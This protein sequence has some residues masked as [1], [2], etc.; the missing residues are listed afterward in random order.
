MNPMSPLPPADMQRLQDAVEHFRAGRAEAALPLA[1]ALAGRHPGVGVVS[2]LLGSV[3]HALGEHAEAAAVLGRAAAELPGDAQAHSNLGNALAVLG[4]IDE[5]IDAHR[6]A[7]R[8]QPEQATL[9]YN[10]GCV[11]LQAG[12]R[13]EAAD[14]WAEAQTRAPDDA[15]LAAL[16]REL[17]LELGDNG[18]LMDFCRA[19]IARGRE[20]GGVL[21]LAGALALADPAGDIDEAER[22]LVAALRLTRD[23]A[24]SWSNLCVLRCRQGRFADAVDAGRQAVA[25]APEWAQGH[26]NLALALREAGAREEARTH[27]LEALQLDGECVDAYYNLGCIAADLGE[28]ELAR[29]AGIEAVKRMPRPGWLLQAAHACRHV[30]D[31][32]AAELLEAELARVCDDPS[33]LPT[34]GDALAPFAFLTVPGTDAAA[35]AAVARAFAAQFERVPAVRRAASAPGARP[36]RV[37]LLSADFRDHATAHLMTGVLEAIDPGRVRLIAYDYGP[38]HDDDYRRRLQ[39]AIPEWVM[40]AGLSDAEAAGRIAADAVDIVIDLKGWTQGFRAPILAYRPAPLQ[41][42]WLGFPGTMGAAWLDYIIADGIVVPA[43]AEAGYSERVLRL[44]GCYQP[45]DGQRPPVTP[46]SRAEAGLPDDALVLA[47]FH[48]HYKI[49]RVSF[50]LWMRLLRGLPDALLWLLEG[51]PSAMARLSKEARAHGVD[52]ARL[53]WAPRVP[54]AHHLNRLAVADIALD[55][56]PVNAHTTASDALW[57][58]V[59]Q[60]ARRGDTF[61]SR[62]SA[63]IL[64]AAGLPELIAADDASYEALVLALGTD[65]GRRQAVRQRVADAGKHAGLF[66]SAAFA[67]HLEDALEW[68]WTRHCAGLP[69]ASTPVP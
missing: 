4:R 69:P 13:S 21:A 6:R 17:L 38:Q 58:G 30:A 41:M 22:W 9:H 52:P 2:K 66:N 65:A 62:V 24:S 12:R 60:V 16:Y 5:A 50:A 44:P 15:E 23:D 56:F 14:A 47:A 68:A 36:L 39:R 48:Q 10:L 37:G 67:R 49:T 18:R 25:A 34:G 61:V 33:G 8:L 29:E 27:C 3:L 51:A 54:V 59:P 31:W 26:S 53:C 7:I 45:N 20:D 11:L 64:D 40:L 43:G 46:L 19:Q 63:S 35:Q 42:Q 55:A 57:A 28:H 1:R 32:E